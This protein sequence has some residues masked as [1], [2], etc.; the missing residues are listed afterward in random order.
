MK[1]LVL[2][3][4][5]RPRVSKF[6]SECVGYRVLKIGQHLAKSWARAQWL[7]YLAYFYLIYR[8]ASSLAVNITL[9]AFA[10]E[11]RAAAPLLLS[12][13]TYY[14]SIYPA[15]CKPAARRCCCQSMGQTDRRTDDGPFHRPCSAYYAGSVNNRV[16]RIPE[17][18]I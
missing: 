14:R 17:I 4:S 1:F 6:I 18:N 5:M 7:F 15:R 13:G 12:A 16:T 10:A 3:W 8:S 2:A 11:R 9:A